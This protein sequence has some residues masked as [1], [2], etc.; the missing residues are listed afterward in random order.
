MRALRPF[1]GIALPA[2]LAVHLGAMLLW[3]PGLDSAGALP[4]SRQV[5]PIPTEVAQTLTEEK[6]NVKRRKEWVRAR[7]RAPPDTD[8]QQIE[9]ANGRR[10]IERRRD[11]H[12]Q[13][14]VDDGSVWTERGSMNLAGRMM[15]GEL[16]ADGTIYAGAASGGVWRQRPGAEWEPLG[17]NLYGGAAWLEILP[18]DQ[19]GGPAVMLAA[20]DWGYLHRSADDGQTWEAPQGLP[21]F[22]ELRRMLHAPDGSVWLVIGEW[23]SYTVWRSADQGRSFSRMV[24]LGQSA[25]DIWTPRDADGPI[26]LFASGALSVSTDD[27]QSWAPASGPVDDGAVGDAW[28][29]GSEADPQATG[30]PRLYLVGAVG[31]GRGVFVSDDSGQTWERRADPPEF[32]SV[33]ECSRRDREL[34]AVGGVEMFRSRDGA[35]RFERVNVWSD[36]YGDPATKLHADM[37]GFDAEQDGSG[38]EVWFVATDGG[39]YRSTDALETVENLSLYGLRVSQYYSTHTSLDGNLAAGAQDQGYQASATMA[40]DGDIL[41]LE[42]LISGDY[43]HLT[44][45]DGTHGYVFSTYPGFILVQIGE[46]SP[47]LDYIDY[48][49]NADALWLPPVVADPADPSAFFFLGDRLWRYS[50]A[51]RRWTPALWSEENFQSQNGEYLSALAFSPVDPDRA[52]ATTSTGRMFVSDDHGV[53]WAPSAD[54]GPSSQYFYGTALLASRYNRDVVYAGGSGYGSPAVYRSADGGQ[55]WAPFSDGLPDTLVYGLAEATDGSGVLVAATETLAFRRDPADAAWRDITGTAAPILTWWAV[56]ALAPSAAPS[57]FRFASYGRGAWD[58]RFEPP[59][60]AP[61]ADVDLDGADCAADCD[62]LDPARAPGLPDNC[63]SI[64]ADCDPAGELD[65]DGD[66]ALG[67]ADCDD[68]DAAVGPT[69]AEV[70]GDGLDN[71]C[72]GGDAACREPKRGGDTCGCA[73][74]P[75]GLALLPLIGALAAR[76]RRAPPAA[77]CR[78]RTTS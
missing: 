5:R 52:W 46:T 20:T 2:F 67:C 56:E 22:N 1:S 53:T 9:R 48:P 18:P 36:Y 62:D 32:W 10:V 72:A 12:R 42:Q 24:D 51:N 66:G 64:D 71:D 23:G 59:A 8:W 13:P 11:L 26:Y 54:Q 63:D 70:C 27:G 14:P 41:H 57:T 45:G 19:E 39:L 68:A 49:D 30:H 47:R 34:F 78:S 15:T 58:Y 50:L 37:M 77:Y 3:L 61:G 73:A 40:Q 29:C 38:Q 75:S 33:L 16:L 7:H 4:V 17:D 74:D 55:T 25:G 28:M 60:C 43:G 35:Q 65:A 69:E 76:R 44:S 21:A 31:G 6:A